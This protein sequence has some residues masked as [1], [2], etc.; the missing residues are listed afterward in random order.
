MFPMFGMPVQPEISEELLD[1]LPET[2]E[3]NQAFVV[4]NNAQ[5]DGYFDRG[6]LANRDVDKDSWMYPI[7]EDGFFRGQSNR[8]VDRAMFPE[9][10][11]TDPKNQQDQEEEN[12]T[13]Y[14]TVRDAPV[15]YQVRYFLNNYAPEIESAAYLVGGLV[16]LRKLLKGE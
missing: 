10:E 3:K 2:V 16:L 14:D 7:Y 8:E 6:F 11:I 12:I 4:W 5:S 15:Q 1:A 13:V 9:R